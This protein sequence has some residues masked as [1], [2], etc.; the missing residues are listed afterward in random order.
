MSTPVTI[1]V[2][3]VAVAAAAVGRATM[4]EV[5]RYLKVRSM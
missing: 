5:K 4:P 2:V 3:A 1:A